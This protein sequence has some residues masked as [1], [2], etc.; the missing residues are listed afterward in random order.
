MSANP[1][2]R[3]PGASEATAPL[4]T[5]TVLLDHLALIRVE[6]ADAAAFL[7]GQFSSDIDALEPGAQQP[8]A[9]CNPKGRAIA[10]YRLLRD[11]T[12]FFLVLP[13]DLADAVVRRLT[14]FRMRAK[15]DI[16]LLPN[17]RLVGVLGSRAPAGLPTWK[18]D[19]Q[20]ILAVQED[21]DPAQPDGDA[22]AWLPEDQWKLATI[23]AGE[24]QVYA[25]TSEAFIPQQV[26]LDLVGGVSFRKGCYPGQEIIARV[27]YL[28]K[29]KQR[30]V[31][32]R[33]AD[34][35]VTA[36]PGDGVFDT[37]RGEQKAGQVVDAVTV[38]GVC[39]LTAT[40]PAERVEDRDFRLGAADG[41]AL[42]VQSMPYEVT[43]GKD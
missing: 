3:S 39:W 26:N 42:V 33:I 36:S 35:G 28:G 16:N 30:M 12:G 37:E 24:P 27:R 14:M 34:P 11:A 4:T 1:V 19:E 2:P 13:R 31:I 20:R 40:L 8:G 17:A 9:Y 10:I 21:G 32:A 22:G 7:Q 43:T 18:L 23:L 29:I 41:P 15:A 5:G 38:E 25:T 6:G